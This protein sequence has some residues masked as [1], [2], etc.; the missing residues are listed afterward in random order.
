MFVR[1]DVY[2][3][4]HLSTVETDVISFADLDINISINH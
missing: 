1:H 4:D 3:V 2:H